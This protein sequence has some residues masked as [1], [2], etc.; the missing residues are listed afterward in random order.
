MRRARGGEGS[1]R[2]RQM[3]LMRRKTVWGTI[4]GAVL[5]L[6]ASFG[7]TAFGQTAGANG[8]TTQGTTRGASTSHI[9]PS[10]FSTKIDNKY[11]P[12]KRGTT[13][14]YRGK[15]EGN[16]ER[17]VMSVTHSTKRIQGVRCV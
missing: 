16:A 4:V 13:F 5:V 3:D 2:E 6:V 15:S 12:L 10:E 8:T 11:F 14:H 17:D 9:K 7:S 1:L